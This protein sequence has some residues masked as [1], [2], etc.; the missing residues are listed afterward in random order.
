MGKKSK[1]NPIYKRQE[2]KPSQRFDL[3]NQT[4][5]RAGAKIVRKEIK[6]KTKINK[7]EKNRGE[8]LYSLSGVLLMDATRLDATCPAHHCLIGPATAATFA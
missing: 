6:E 8:I 4:R 3:M 1:S 5:T 7:Q 2:Q